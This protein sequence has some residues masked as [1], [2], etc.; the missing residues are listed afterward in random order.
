VTAIVS[1]ELRDSINFC[2][3]TLRLPE[4]KKE[5][6]DDLEKYHT[7]FVLEKKI[8]KILKSDIE[9]QV[10]H[11]YAGGVSKCYRFVMI[12]AGL[13]KG[14]I[15]IAL[16]VCGSGY[17]RYANTNEIILLNTVSLLFILE[18]DD[19]IYKCLATDI[20]KR[21]ISNETPAISLMRGKHSVLGKQHFLQDPKNDRHLQRE[22]S[23]F[24]LLAVSLTVCIVW[25][26]LC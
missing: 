5:Y 10:N 15:E 19:Y 9:C 3:W 22:G 2:K 7:G 24:I 18:I 14:G 12:V 17:I 21:F 8:F 6:I 11:I 25:L 13:V 26:S 1:S 20:I 4:W 23:W 16:L